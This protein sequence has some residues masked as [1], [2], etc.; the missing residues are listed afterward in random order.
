M[1]VYKHVYSYISVGS[2]IF[3][4]QINFKGIDL[5]FSLSTAYIKN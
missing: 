4:S 3:Y 2:E 1:T 5:E